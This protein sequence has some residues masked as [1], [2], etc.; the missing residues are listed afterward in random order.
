MTK[1]FCTSCWVCLT[2]HRRARLRSHTPRAHTF[3]ARTTGKERRRKPIFYRRF[4]RVEKISTSHRSIIFRIMSRRISRARQ[5]ATSGAT[6]AQTRFIKRK[7]WFFCRAVVIRMR[8]SRSPR[9]LYD[10]ATHS[11][12]RR[13]AWRRSERRRRSQRRKR[14]QGRP[15]AGR[16]SKHTP[17]ASLRL[18][19]TSMTASHGPARVE[20]Q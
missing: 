16:R 8:C 15:S 1:K 13:A 12:A 10:I 18:R 17:L 7:H 5:D 20:E 14:A 9:A 19:T 11:L 2:L 6:R 4:Q 3:S